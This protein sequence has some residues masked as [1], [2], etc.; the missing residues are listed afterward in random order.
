MG[1]DVQVG[2]PLVTVA[3]ACSWTGSPTPT[4]VEPGVTL[5]P[6]TVEGTPC[7]TQAFVPRV[8]VVE[9]VLPLSAARRIARAVAHDPERLPDE[10]AGHLDEASRLG[11]RGRA[12]HPRDL[13][14]DVLVA[15]VREEARR[16]AHDAEAHAARQAPGL[17]GP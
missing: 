5:I 9:D 10:V 3:S 11:D 2:S 14:G 1:G 7:T 17:A 4:L 13:V 8:P 15:R 6:V 16:L 12:R